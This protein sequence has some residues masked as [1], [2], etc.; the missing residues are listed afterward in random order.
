VSAGV[1]FPQAGGC[2]CGDVRYRLEEDPLTLYACHCTDC[3]TQSGTSFSLSLV[4]RR[5]SLRIERGSPL[6]CTLELPDGRRKTSR[7]CGRCA[8][9]I[10]APARVTGLAI[11]EPGTLDDTSWLQPV[12]HVWTASAQP[13][14]GIPAAVLRFEGP[15][16]EE[17]FLDLVRAWK[18]R[19]SR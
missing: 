14:L 5:E 16:G 1:A 6:E 18:E 3:Q 12:G 15:P 11:L 2:L 10:S 13:W 8:T 7:Y 9:R 17:A 19:S 4:V